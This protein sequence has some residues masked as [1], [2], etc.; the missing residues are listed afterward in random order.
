MTETGRVAV[1][2]APGELAY[3]E[4]PVPTAAPDELVL[5]I[6][7]AN[8]CGSELHIWNGKHPVKK[9][10]G[11][12]HEMLGVVRE[13][14]ARRQVDN[15]GEPLAV[16]DR[17]VVTYFQ[18]C[19]ECFQCLQGDRN[20]CDRAYEFFAKQP[21]EAPHFHSAFATHYVV[22]PKQHVF[23]VPDAIPDAVAAGANCALS[24]VMFGIS[25]TPLGYGA[26]FLIQG[27][28]GLGLNAIPVAKELGARV[29]VIDGVASR[30]EQAKAFGAD[31]T[32]DMSEVTDVDARVELVRS[33]TDGRG[34]DVALEVTGVPAAFGEGLEHVRRGGTYLVMGNLS[35]G[36]T[37]PFDPG[38]VTRKALTIRHVDRYEGRWLAKAID[39]LAA[40][41]ER[42]P[43]D[44]LVDAEFGFDR[45]QD[46]LDQSLA[47][48]VT[49]AAVVLR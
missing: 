22:H 47:R 18:T 41:L 21:E 12:G 45:I 25:K 37:V 4:Y 31:H 38:Y 7:R 34:P 46:A 33:L 3:Q 17:V 20:L 15:R 32:I 5:E 8:V 29:I 26:T 19:E 43:F 36:A 30:L 13:L 24:Q 49:R 39:F 1:M 35:P 27:A 23:K 6:A 10:G 16:G 28:G 9:R 40:N 11:L 2:T 44:H 14:G 48:T 42:Y